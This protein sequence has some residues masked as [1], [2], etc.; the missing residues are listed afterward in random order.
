MARPEDLMMFEMTLT[1]TIGV[2]LFKL[3]SEKSKQ[4]LRDSVKELAENIQQYILKQPLVE[5][6]KMNIEEKDEA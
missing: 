5:G 6:I 4:G 3:Q 1:I 2:P